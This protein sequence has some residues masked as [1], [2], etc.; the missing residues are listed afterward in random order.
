MKTYFVLVSLLLGSEGLAVEEWDRDAA[1]RYL[2]ER[3]ELWIARSRP[4]QKLETACISCH[5][6][7]TYLLARPA[8]DPSATPEPARALFA[9]AAKRV[10]SFDTAKVWYDES[11][12]AEKPDQSRGTESVLNALVLTARDRRAGSPL[13]P[14]AKAALARMWEQQKDDGHWS[15]LHF[16]LG[17]WETD[18]SEYWGAA[19]A[20]VA[21]GED[22]DAPPAGRERLR[23]YLREGLSRD[24]S[25]HNR[26]ALLWASSGFPDLLSPSERAGLVE[27]VLERQRFDGG[28]RLQ[29]LGSWPSKDGTPPREESDGYA[30]AFTTFVL[31]QLDAVECAESI[32]RG[33]AWLRQ[34][35]KPDGRWETLSPN[36]DRSK[37]EEFTRLLASD[38]ATAFAVLALA[39]Y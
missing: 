25:L 8:L 9:D 16:G 4:R 23:R 28:F 31:Q 13:S 30:T 2:D 38:A 36:K 34:N 17:P 5:T 37:E 21:A 35:Q 32:E 39:R 3:A 27:E 11:R 26:L 10:A 19:L 14:V 33:L 6:A 15:W 29:D 22:S 18:G 12:G 1:A 24:E 20:A 7:L